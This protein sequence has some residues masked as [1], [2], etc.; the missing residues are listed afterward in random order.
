MKSSKS[1][2]IKKDLTAKL[3][4]HDAILKQ[5]QLKARYKVEY[6]EL[7]TRYESELERSELHIAK[8]KLE[9]IDGQSI[10]TRVD[11]PDERL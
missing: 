5:I 3:A 10:R 1:V 8:A 6:L 9:A 11:L 2:S 7:K 4:E